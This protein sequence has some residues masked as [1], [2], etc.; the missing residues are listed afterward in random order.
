MIVYNAT[1]GEFVQDVRDNII[2]DKILKLIREKGLNAGQ[3]WGKH[4]TS[5]KRGVFCFYQ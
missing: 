4:N 1:K 5:R 2:A 3:D